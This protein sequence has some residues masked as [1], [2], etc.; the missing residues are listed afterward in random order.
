MTKEVNKALANGIDKRKS[1]RGYY[2]RMK[3]FRG[4]VER[5]NTGFRKSEPTR[6]LT[7]AYAKCRCEEVAA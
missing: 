2:R 7:C 3:Y 4:E 6:C 1:R 5:F